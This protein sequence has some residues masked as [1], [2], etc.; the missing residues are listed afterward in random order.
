MAMVGENLPL[1]SRYKGS[2][3]VFLTQP[4]PASLKLLREV[5]SV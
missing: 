3:T 5:R 1:L 4:S 2:P